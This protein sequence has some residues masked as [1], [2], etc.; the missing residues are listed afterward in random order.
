MSAPDTPSRRPMRGRW[1]RP[2]FFAR[3]GPDFF[4]WAIPLYRAA[5]I[6]VSVH[7]IYILM[8]LSEVLSAMGKDSWQFQWVA[9]GIVCLFVLVLLHE[10]G[11]CFA[12]RWV[13][14]DADQILMWPLG[15]LAFCRPP[16]EWRASLITTLGGPGVNVVLTPLLGAALLIAGC[17]WAAVVF[18]PFQP[19]GAMQRVQLGDGSRPMW[20]LVVWWLHYTNLLLLAFN[21]LLPMYPMDGARTLHALLWWRLGHDR[22]LRIVAN[23]GVACAI[24][25]LLYALHKEQGRLIGLA[26]FGGLTCWNER[27]R[28]QMEGPSEFARGLGYEQ[29]RK[30]QARR[31]KQR[32]RALRETREL[33]EKLDRIL[34]KVAQHGMAS[35]S[36]R[37]KRFLRQ[38]TE[39]R[40]GR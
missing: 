1:A 24:G 27:R 13:G 8:T 20:L 11:H 6:R 28:L 16:H 3:L 36:E 35:R 22:A 10:Y 19:F 12:C 26:L 29:E 23:V 2:G 4:S 17:G 30:E 15:G 38:E 32:E 18:D 31:A 40:A 33:Q 25:L 14:G 9:I 7:V 34:E 5:G 39:R 37:E 21:M